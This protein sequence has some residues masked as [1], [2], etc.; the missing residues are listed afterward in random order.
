MTAQ[1]G[2]HRLVPDELDVLVAREGERHDE[3]P[4]APRYTMS[5]GQQRPGAEV[6]LGRLGGLEVQPDRCRRGLALADGCDQAVN[7]RVAA[8]KAVVATQGCVDRDTL[9]ALSV[10]GADELLPRCHRRNGRASAA[11]LPDYLRQFRIGGHR[12][13]GLEPAVQLRQLAKRRHLLA[14]HQATAVHYPVGVAL[15]QPNQDLSVLKHLESPAAHRSTPSVK[16]TGWW[17][18]RTIGFET[19]SMLLS[20][21]NMPKSHWPDYAEIGAGSL[22]C[23]CRKPT[24]LI[25]V[26][27]DKGVSGWRWRR[28]PDRRWATAAKSC[29]ERRS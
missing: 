27:D 13:V 29:I 19:L 2:R 21:L 3:R 5:I 18:D 7:R 15:A 26:K 20:G 1:P 14:A 9:N 22:A 23:I 11:R 10:P 28:W 24:G 8:G 6:H 4:G 12:R 25:T 17:T 16:L